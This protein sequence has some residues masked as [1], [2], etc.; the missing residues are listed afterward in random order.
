MYWHR[1][2]SAYN[3]ADTSECVLSMRNVPYTTSSASDVPK[4]REVWLNKSAKVMGAKL[5]SYAPYTRTSPASSSSSSLSK[6]HSRRRPSRPQTR[7]ERTKVYCNVVSRLNDDDAEKS[8]KQ[9]RGHD[10]NALVA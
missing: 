4:R 6:A 5:M 7:S 3:A 1:P 9:C 2:I 10:S 8:Y